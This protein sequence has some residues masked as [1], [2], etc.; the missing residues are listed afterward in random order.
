MTFALEPL[1]ILHLAARSRLLR[2]QRCA[3][4]TLATSLRRR[5]AAAGAASEFFLRVHD[6]LAVLEQQRRKRVTQVVNADVAKVGLVEH[7]FEYC[8]DVLFARQGQG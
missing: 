7:A 8:S 4:A 3:L 2:D 5:P 6:G 1:C